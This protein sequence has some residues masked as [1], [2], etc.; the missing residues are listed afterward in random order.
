MIRFVA[1]LGVC[2]AI[3]VAL[4][5]YGQY[6]PLRWQARIPM[7]NMRDV[8]ASVGK[9]LHVSTNAHGSIEWDYTRWWSGTA[10]VYFHTNGAFYRIFTEW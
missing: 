6:W 9:P 7:T 5:A 2:A 10:K 3:A 1:S 8:E 4:F